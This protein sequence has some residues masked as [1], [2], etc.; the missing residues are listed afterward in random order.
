PK[1]VRYR[2]VPEPGRWYRDALGNR[3]GRDALAGQILIEQVSDDVASRPVVVDLYAQSPV[4][5]HLVTAA[6][7]RKRAQI[8]RIVHG[9]GERHHETGKHLAR[10]VDPR[11]DDLLPFLR[12]SWPL[13]V[14]QHEGGDRTVVKGFGCS[15]GSGL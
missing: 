4:S 5:Q 13:P 15:E 3:P 14:F 11:N 1:H 2:L 12:R 7:H 9:A 10:I 6:L 8:A